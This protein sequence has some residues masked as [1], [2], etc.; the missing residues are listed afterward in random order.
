LS[1]ASPKSPT[2]LVIRPFAIDDAEALGG[3]IVANLW[4]VNIRDYGALVVSRLAA[5]Y[6]P[7]Q[8][9]D[10]ARTSAIYVAAEAASGLV[11]TVTL[12]AERVRNM[13]VR[14]DHHRQGVGTVLMQ[15]V[16]RVARQ[17]GLRH[18]YL[19]ANVAAVGFYWKLGY[20]RMEEI[21]A[22]L[23]DVPVKLVRMEKA[24]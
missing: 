15:Y 9:C 5:A 4:Q 2:D 6:G 11:G 22:Y 7:D 24:L 3:L 23:G 8:L 17:Q 16:E 10:Y 20:A 13:F 12:D 14:L 18:L 21:E 19:Q 1:T